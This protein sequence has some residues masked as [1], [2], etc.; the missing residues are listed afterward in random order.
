MSL[1]PAPLGRVLGGS[2]APGL[3]EIEASGGL[4]LAFGPCR[5]A[6]GAFSSSRQGMARPASRGRGGTPHVRADI[7]LRSRAQAA[8]GRRR[9][10]VARCQGRGGVEV[11][12]GPAKPDSKPPAEASRR[13]PPRE[14]LGAT[15]TELRTT[16]PSVRS[17]DATATPRERRPGLR[18]RRFRIR[19]RIPIRGAGSQRACSGPRTRHRIDRTARLAVP[20]PGGSVAELP[21]AARR[22]E[23]ARE[24]AA[25]RPPTASGV[26]RRRGVG[27]RSQ[28]PPVS[29]GRFGTAL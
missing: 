21:M 15:A 19:A 10:V 13:D 11:S 6:R 22:F 7:S 5:G 17:A 3:A 29:S 2:V 24:H 9:A 18:G 27:A 12:P 4:S 14:R 28:A 1:A 8:P 26:S 20:R 16:L 23:A 25:Q